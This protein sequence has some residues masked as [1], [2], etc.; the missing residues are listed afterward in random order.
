MRQSGEMDAKIR[1]EGGMHLQAAAEAHGARRFIAQS[2]AFWYAP[3]QGLA[4]ENEPFALEATPN[5]SAGSRLYAEIEQRVLESDRIEGVA[6]RFGFFYGP[7]TW[8]RRHG[9]VADQLF[10]KQ[11]PLIGDGEGVWNFVHIEDAA[12]AI[13]SAVYC[14]PGAYNIVN[15]HP[16]PMREWL[17]A[18]ARYVGSEPPV[19]ITEE[20]GLKQKG[21]DLVY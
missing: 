5:I 4:N 12:N 17:P 2:A 8:F 15:N 14:M 16:S 6:L 19:R 21:A 20:E 3:G 13:V 9:N 1:R 11:F 18:L 10:H 7:G